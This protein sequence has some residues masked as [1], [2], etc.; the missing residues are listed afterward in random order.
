MRD[1]KC[2]EDRSI[3]TWQLFHSLDAK[4][5][6]LFGKYNLEK[7]DKDHRVTETHV[8]SISL[9]FDTIL[10][11]TWSMTRDGPCYTEK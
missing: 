1:G 10:S 7:D 4:M 11:C 9:I 2:L 5:W 6:S 3:K 8:I